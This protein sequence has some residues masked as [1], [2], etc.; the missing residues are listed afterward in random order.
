MG[1]VVYKSQPGIDRTKGLVPLAGNEYIYTVSKLLWPDA[2]EE[3]LSTQLKGF[4]LHVCCGKSKLGNIRLD[5]YE[6]SAHIKGDMSRLPFPNESFDTVIIDPPY[7][8][9]FQIMHDMLSEL[10]RVSRGRIIFQHWFS[11]VDKKGFY[12]KNHK[13]TLTGLYAWMPKTYFGRMQIVS[14]F[15]KN[16]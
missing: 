7:N 9:R 10:C 13:F 3:F 12:K 2:V 16:A 14:V 5:L 11:P 4:T 8:S 6:P 1:T 15:D